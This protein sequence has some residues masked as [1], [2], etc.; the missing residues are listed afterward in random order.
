MSI[1]EREKNL[2]KRWKEERGYTSFVSD[3]VFDEEIWNQQKIKITFVLK[4]ANW[5]NC[6]VD[7]CKWI[8]SEP[9][10]TYWKTWNNIARWTKALL[11]KGE[12][13]R[14]VSKEDKT[15]WLSKVSFIN[16]KKVG[17]SSQADD[18]VIRSYAKNDKE[19]LLE[20]LMLYKPDIIICCGRGTGKNADL[21]YEEILP[22]KALSDWKQTKNGFNYFY[23]L[24][25]GKDKSTP[26]ISFYHPQRIA[27]H[28]LFK[29]WYGKM[30]QI[31]EQF[32]V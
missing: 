23:C 18:E 12:Y 9:K 16:L 10:S 17:G 31:G 6:T 1:K 7:L 14:Y 11:V 15:F 26:V 20:Q 2:F 30:V 32:L 22:K 28:E 29:D 25:D 21:L 4:E 8:L 13:P 3:G 24:F 5:E 19:F 27:G